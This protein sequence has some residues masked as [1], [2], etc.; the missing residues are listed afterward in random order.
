MAAR[1]LP[2]K[3]GL[4]SEHITKVQDSQGRVQKSSAPRRWAPKEMWEKMPDKFFP[5]QNLPEIRHT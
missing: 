2:R 3:E 4:D 5:F 1:T